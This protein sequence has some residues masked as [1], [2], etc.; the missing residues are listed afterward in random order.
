MPEQTGSPIRSFRDLIVWQ[1]AMD[2]V[3]TCHKLTKGFPASEL[4]GLSAQIQRAAVS[5][6]AN[7]AEGHARRHTGD[8][9]RHLS[10]AAGSLAE[11]ETHLEAAMRLQMLSKKDLEVTLIQTAEIGRMLFTLIRKL[12]AKSQ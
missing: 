12:R 11:L 3:V 4:Y 10:Y 8:Y 9:V 5:V 6:P 7:I 1:K 2:L